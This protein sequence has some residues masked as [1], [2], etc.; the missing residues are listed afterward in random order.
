M[1]VGERGSRDPVSYLYNSGGHRVVT[2]HGEDGCHKSK[3]MAVAISKVLRLIATLNLR[4]HA[5]SS[6]LLMYDGRQ[7]E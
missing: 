6:F 1:I 3:K 2:W 5:D 4:R 7:N